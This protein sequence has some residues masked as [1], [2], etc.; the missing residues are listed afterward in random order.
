MRVYRVVARVCLVVAAVGLAFAGAAS[1]KT[2][3]VMPGK[4]SSI[5]DVLQ[6]AEPGDTVLLACGTFHESS[7]LVPSG[8][9]LEGVGAPGCVVIQGDGSAP[10]VVMEDADA[11]TAIANLTLMVDYTGPADTTLKGAEAQP[12]QAVTRG[13][14]FRTLSSS[15][16]RTAA[17][18]AVAGAAAVLVPIIDPTSIPFMKGAYDQHDAVVHRAV[19]ARV[20][21]AAAI[22]LE[23]RIEEELRR[24]AEAAGGADRR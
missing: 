21:D 11:T 1:A 8:V 20:E 12:G 15:A 17:S 13:S 10:L 5:N 16:S 24:H 22:R 19:V 18:V 3:E 6:Q 2:F 4:A 23:R 9:T 7:L 14:T